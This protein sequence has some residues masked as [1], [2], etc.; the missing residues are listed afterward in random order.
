MSIYKAAIGDH[1]KTFDFAGRRDC[2]IQGHVTAISTHPHFG[3]EVVEVT[4]T[5]E[6]FGGEPKPTAKV[7]YPPQ[8][9]TPTSMGETTNGIELVRS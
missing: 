1:V 3:Y 2:Y 4:G 9:G 5:H 6:A 8:N 7:V